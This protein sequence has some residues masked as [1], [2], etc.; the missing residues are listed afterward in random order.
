[1]ISMDKESFSGLVNNLLWIIICFA[2]VS[3]ILSPFLPWIR[4]SYDGGSILMSEAWISEAAEYD[5]EWEDINS[6]IFYINIG[7]WISL[8]F[9]LIGLIGIT[10]F[11]SGRGEY[12]SI[13]F[14]LVA[15]GFIPFSLL[16]TI[17]HVFFYN[18]VKALGD[19]Y[20][21]SYNY[22]PLIAGIS[23]LVCSIIY[24][25]VVVPFSLKRVSER[26]D[27]NYEKRYD[28]SFEDMYYTA[29]RYEDMG[30]HLTALELYEN[31]NA[32]R[33]VER[34]TRFLAKRCVKNGRYDDAIQLY[35]SSE[36]WEEADAIE[37]LKRKKA[38]KSSDR[39]C[40]ECGTKIN[41]KDD[42]CMGC[43]TPVEKEDTEESPFGR[44]VENVCPNC[45]SPLEPD[46][47]FCMGC[48]RKMT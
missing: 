34:V 32:V 16:T 31:V 33:D 43:G 37:R 3:L 44:D 13:S 45:E 10:I 24:A 40:E 8:I 36:M 28:G 11:K 42:Y 20:S 1:M 27:E 26:M 29:Q 4:V 19:D 5:R 23:L 18:N 48:G 15:L 35:E 22:A 41:E 25:V 12:L 2:V 38:G 14:M 6:N 17:T 30:D 47:S 7:I 9:A 39:T 21:L 46:D